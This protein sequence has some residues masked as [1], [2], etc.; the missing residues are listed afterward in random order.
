MIMTRRAVVACALG[1]TQCAG[2]PAPGGGQGRPGAAA[3]TL[4]DGAT[5]SGAPAS[6]GIRTDSLTIRPSTGPQPRY[7][8]QAG[9]T[10]SEGEAALLAKVSRRTLRHEPGLSR[11]ARELART[12][13]VDQV[14]PAGLI[15]GLMAWSGLVEPPPR[16]G[17]VEVGATCA[18]TPGAQ[19]CPEAIAALASE[20]EGLLPREGDGWVGVGI[21]DLPGGASRLILAVT[22]RTVA[23]D[24]IDAEVALN[25]SVTLKGRLLGGRSQPRVET[26]DARG[27]WRQVAVNAGRGGELSATFVCA[28]Q[29]ALRVEVLAEGPHG[30]EVSANFPLFCGSPAPRAIT[31]T[32]EQVGAEVDVG[33]IERANFDALNQARTERGLAPLRWDN[34]AAAAARAHSRDMVENNYLGHRSPSSGEVSDRFRVAGITA[35]RLRENV[36]RGYGPRSMHEALMNSPGH[37]INMLAD[38]VTMVGIGAVIGAPESTS[39]GAARP[40]LLTQNFYAPPGADLPKEPGTALKAEVER[41]RAEA[42][43]RPL[44]WEP[45]LERAAAAMA[46]AVAAGDSAGS[47]KI[48]AKELEKTSLARVESQQVIS[49]EFRGLVGLELWRDPSIQTVG[50]GVAV[51]EGGA[52]AGSVAL[53]VLIAR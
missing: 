52:R 11:M 5:G 32:A 45:T 2:Q 40:I 53:I 21:A 10:L 42:K 24:P 31:V 33:A 6:P 26:V 20:I 39:P 48:M 43:A 38:D 28:T 13:P 12:A 22:E 47:Q 8:A 35:A 1:L 25:A 50:L 19:G 34:A 44:R 18:A 29:G 30:P 37:R 9:H 51:F 36:A 23:L 17:V 27:Q 46:K 7:G 16:I 41:I 14:I 49:S 4:P 3:V 15:E